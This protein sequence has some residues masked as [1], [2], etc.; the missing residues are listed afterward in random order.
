MLLTLAVVP[1]PDVS[2][3]PPAFSYVFLQVT[4]NLI[5]SFIDYIS[6][7]KAYVLQQLSKER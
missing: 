6:I 1:F 7:S 4:L 5:Y 3:H 2:V